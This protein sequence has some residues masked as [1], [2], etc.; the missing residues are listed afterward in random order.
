MALLGAA[1]AAAQLAELNKDNKIDVKVGDKTV[2][3]AVTA[4][5]YAK[6]SE[7]YLSELTTLLPKSKAAEDESI[8]D[9]QKIINEYKGD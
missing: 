4:E 1:N 6:L 3:K 2:K 9:I 8:P 5:T 7:K